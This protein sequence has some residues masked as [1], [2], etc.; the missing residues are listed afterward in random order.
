M[1]SSLNVALLHGTEKT[2]LMDGF[3]NLTIVSITFKSKAAQRISLRRLV[4]IKMCA[5]KK[6][7]RRVIQRYFSATESYNLIFLRKLFQ[8]SYI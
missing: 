1:Y 8:P 7:E 3:F 2:V 5:V 4:F 6:F